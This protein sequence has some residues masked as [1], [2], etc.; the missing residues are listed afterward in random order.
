ML[1]RPAVDSSCA[2]ARWAMADSRVSVGAGVT[3]TVARM[4]PC[5]GCGTPTDSVRVEGSACTTGLSSWTG[6]CAL[7]ARGQ[8]AQP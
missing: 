3:N 5:C 4:T 2:D 1:L 8:A 6:S 7:K